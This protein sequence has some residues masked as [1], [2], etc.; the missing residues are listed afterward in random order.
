MHTLNAIQQQMLAHAAQTNTQHIHAIAAVA[1]TMG[2]VATVQHIVQQ[3]L[4][5]FNCEEQHA[6]QQTLQAMLCEELATATMQ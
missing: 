1:A 3:Y 4:H 6:L 5:L 2:D